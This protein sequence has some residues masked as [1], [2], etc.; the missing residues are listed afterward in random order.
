MI[1][2]H[3]IKKVPKFRT[4]VA[5]LKMAKLM[6]KNIVDALPRSTD[7]MAANDEVST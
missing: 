5:V 1:R 2:H 4:V 6:N 7:D 3:A